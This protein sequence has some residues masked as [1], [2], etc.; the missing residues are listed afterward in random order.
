MTRIKKLK[1]IKYPALLGDKNVIATAWPVDESVYLKINEIIDELNR[2][3]KLLNKHLKT[4]HITNIKK[5]FNS[6]SGASVTF[7]LLGPARP[8]GNKSCQQ[9]EDK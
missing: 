9:E 8:A 4:L 6:L 3:E 5:D 7:G 1:R 2:R